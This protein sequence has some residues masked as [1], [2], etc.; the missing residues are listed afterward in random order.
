MLDKNE[1]SEYALMANALRFLCADMVQRA[2]SG[3]P[4]APMGLADVAVVL[5][6]HLRVI[7]KTQIG[8]TATAWCLVA[9][10]R[11]RLCILCCI[12]G[13]LM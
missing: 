4:G 8:L 13:G 11:V 1:M 7:L 6:Y 9:D 2:N 3:H 10:T 12:Y 5:G